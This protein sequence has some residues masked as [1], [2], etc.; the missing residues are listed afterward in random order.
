MT[1]FTNLGK[2]TNV[3]RLIIGQHGCDIW[4]KGNATLSY[5]R[6]TIYDVEGR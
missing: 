1:I 4:I 3:E 2:F 5:P 6:I